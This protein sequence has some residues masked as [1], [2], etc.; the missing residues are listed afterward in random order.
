MKKVLICSIDNENLKN[1]EP[2]LKDHGELDFTIFDLSNFHKNEIIYNNDVDKIYSSI[3][4]KKPFYLLNIYQKLKAVLNFRKEIKKIIHEFDIVICGRVGIL[5]FELIKYL[6]K[7][8]NTLAYS[9]NDSILIYHEQASIFKR[10][11]LI[12]YK[13]QVRQNICKKIFVSGTVSKNTLIK[14]G[15]K[16][17]KIIISGL[18]RFKKYFNKSMNGTVK[19]AFPKILV[20]TGAHE[21]NGYHKWQEDQNEFLFK[22]DCLNIKNVIINIKPHP[23]DNFEFNQLSKLN[24]LDKEVNIDRAIQEH[25]IV[26][27]ATSLSTALMQAGLLNKK[28]LFINT[29]DLSYLM[30]SYDYYISNFPTIS[31]TELVADFY[32]KALKNNANVLDKFISKKS[33]YSTEIILNE[34][35]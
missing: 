6:K 27:C 10:L 35:T 32:K 17:D 23:R 3:D 24:I 34:I 2:L 7:N 25:D 14:D 15:V 21:W 11:R 29:R 31:K 9:I 8:F 28:T 5:E 26:I 12:I 13:F 16:K 22:L 18:P 19:N 33:L 20:L 1:F 4:V 30:D